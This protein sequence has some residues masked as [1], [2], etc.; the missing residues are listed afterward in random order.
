MQTHYLKDLVSAVCPTSEYSF[1]NYLVSNKKYYR[2]LSTEQSC[3][4][5]QEFSDYLSWA[6]NKM[7]NVLFDSAVDNIEEVDGLYHI[8]TKSAIY[9]ARHICLGTGKAP[10]FPECAKPSL[11]ANVF[12]AAEVG[13]RERN[14]SGRN[15]T[16]IGGGQSGADIFLNVLREQ[17]GKP[18]KLNWV[19]RRAN[20]QPLDEAAFT[21]E[22][23]TPDYVETFVGLTEKVKQRE[24]AHQKLTS[25]GITQKCLLEIYQELYQRFDVMNEQPWVQ[26]LP[27]R[28]LVAV[29]ESSNQIALQ[30]DNAMTQQQE[31]DQTDIVILA[32]GYQ[33]QL[34]SCAKNL[35]CKFERDEYK[36][37]Q[38]THHFS[39]E[40]KAEDES[41]N[42][43]VVN[44]GLHS[45]G[46]AEPQLSLAAWRA[47][48]IINQVTKQRTF[49]IESKVGLINWGGLPPT[50]ED[51]LSI[52][53]S[54]QFNIDKIVN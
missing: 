18:S 51:D 19:T 39:I 6:S 7:P 12:H 20:Y 34:P 32:T 53:K 2:F 5:R 9:K 52:A 42:V 4:S 23:F 43:F 28:T 15:V 35:E 49:D 14:F 17:W 54:N 33:G 27:H 13:L 30:Y 16:I 24:I 46:I 48:K 36:Q 40:K 3:I 37:M 47:A 41:G 50:R 44:A 25:D 21:N 29:A 26:L 10:Y 38:L 11:G 45:H 22:Y 8:H 1:L 31:Q